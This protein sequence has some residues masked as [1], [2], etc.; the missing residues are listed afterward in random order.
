MKYIITLTIIFCTLPVMVKSQN[1]S[2]E[3]STYGIQTGIV[4]F[5]G[6]NESKLSNSIALR[7]ELGLAGGIYWH[8]NSHISVFEYAL[9]PEMTLEPRWYY[10]L[11]KRK[12]KG[13]NINGNSGN[14][15]S[16]NVNYFTDWFIISNVKNTEIDSQIWIVPSWGIKRNIGNHFTFET[17]VG[18][19]A[20]FYLENKDF[21]DNESKI[22]F[23]LHLRIGYRF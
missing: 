5:W 2:V 17:G 21:N 14:F 19:G 4:G 12:K 18:I 15:L 13:K 8:S 9:T 7:T 11:N 1:A 22:I 3:K 20:K 23:N 10:N 6:H 16:L